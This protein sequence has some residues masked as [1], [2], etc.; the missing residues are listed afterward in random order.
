MTGPNFSCT[1]P[2]FSVSNSV[3]VSATDVAGNVSTATLSVTVS[4]SAP[5]ALTVTPGPANLLI[6][7]QQSFTAVDQTGTRRP[8]A[9][10]TVSDPT[11]ANFVSG[12]P[13]TL[14]GVAAGQATLTATVGST[15]GQTTVTVLSGTSLPAGTVLW[16]ANPV[17]GFTAQKIVQAVPTAGGP[18]LYSIETDSSSNLLIRAFQSDGQQLW[19]APLGASFP[20]QFY[21]SNAAGDNSGG[22]LLWDSNHGYMTDVNPQ[23]GQSNWQYA[24]PYSGLGNGFGPDVAL[25]P[26]GI[27]YIVDGDY[28]GQG[29]SALDGIDG[30]S[31]ALVSQMQLPTSSVSYVWDT[32]GSQNGTQTF[33]G[34]YGPPVVAS[35]GTVYL[36]AAAEQDT[37]TYICQGTNETS[38]DTFLNTLQ[39]VQSTG[40]VQTL[41]SFDVCNLC[42]IA[43]SGPGEVIP[44]GYGGVLASWV[45]FP[46]GYTRVPIVADIGPQGGAQQTSVPEATSDDSMVLG[47]NNAAFVTDGTTV[48]ALSVPGL[49]VMWNYTSSGGTLSFVAATQGGGVAINDSQQGLIQLDSSGNASAPFV[50]LQ[51][52]SPFLGAMQATFTEQ[53][54]ALT[55]AWVGLSSTELSVFAG[56]FLNLAPSAFGFSA[57]NETQDRGAAQAAYPVGFTTELLPRKPD[58]FLK[59]NYSWYS[60]TGTLNKKRL[61]DLALCE[62]GET[63]RYPV[64]PS[65]IPSDNV[66]FDW[67]SP[68][69][70]RTLA[71][72]STSVTARL[73]KLKDWNE[74]PDGGF[75]PPYQNANFD[76]KQTIWWR[77]QNVDENAQHNF[78]SEV[79]ITRRVY[80]DSD[81]KWKYQ[82]IKNTDTSVLVLPNQ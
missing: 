46:N 2:L 70:A 8:D 9:T 5:T 59:W 45:D 65:N 28:N 33:S 6:G 56:A 13:N 14:Q 51:G 10:W 32:C 3:V 82:I 62:V 54:L 48:T 60:S 63:V 67:P 41:R 16:S 15:T 23:S 73:G 34:A 79:T 77:C 40:Q 58:G 29:L 47:D 57:G 36:E 61:R 68:M 53:G 22:L 39:L 19:Q 42:D 4:M 55:G 12:S 30:N 43:F 21:L 17:A 76:S 25:G 80:L 75:Q 7:Q 49:Q 50:A 1:V 26:N 11:I 18:D 44:D 66:S 37:R 38:G 64:P 81:G 27:V 74:P 72:A 35:D 69:V 31:G 24:T 20:N 78:I 71:D 52:T